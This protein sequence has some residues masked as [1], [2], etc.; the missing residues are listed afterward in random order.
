MRLSLPLL[1]LQTQL[2]YQEQADGRRYLW[3]RWRQKYVLP[4]PEELVRQLL[5]L[6]LTQQRDYP[7]KRVAVE[8]QLTINGLSR[9]FDALFYNAQFEPLLLIECK[10]PDV[11]L[12]SSV[13]E[14]IAHYNAALR[15]PYLLLSNGIDSYFLAWQSEQAQFQMLPALPD[16]AAL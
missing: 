16:Y 15:L 6:Y 7:T 5:L 1:P 14:Q 13:F 3:D 10:A 4:Q 2:Q 9:R 12:N 8:R 11:P